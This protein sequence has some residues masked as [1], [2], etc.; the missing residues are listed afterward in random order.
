MEQDAEWV[1][2]KVNEF[3]RDSA[4]FVLNRP[5]GNKPVSQEDQHTEWELAMLDPAGLKAS[6]EAYANLVG[7]ENAAAEF[8]KWDAKHRKMGP[9]PEP[10]PVPAIPPN[11]M[12]GM[13]AQMPVPMNG[14][15]Q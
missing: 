8:L 7:P 13:G 10:V 4:E 11:P 3:I 9:P 15:M 14:A 2:E 6:F 12:G 5:P 1:A